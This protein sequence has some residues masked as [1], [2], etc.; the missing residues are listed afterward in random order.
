MSSTAPLPTK[1][2]P[3]R[4]PRHAAPLWMEVPRCIFCLGTAATWNPDG[5]AERA[6]KEAVRGPG[7][8]KSSAA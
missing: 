7:R 6:A 4:L 2:K 5:C 1:P 8:P 3:R